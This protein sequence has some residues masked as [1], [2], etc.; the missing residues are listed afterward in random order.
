MSINSGLGTDFACQIPSVSAHELFLLFIS[1]HFLY[2]PCAF[3]SEA[4]WGKFS[5]FASLPR[6]QSSQTDGKNGF[7]IALI[8]ISI[9]GLSID[10][11]QKLRKN[12]SHVLSK[13]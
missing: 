6:N 11:H 3:F 2:L 4:I 8:A 9:H 1:N 13:N 10:L 7:L 5:K 12:I